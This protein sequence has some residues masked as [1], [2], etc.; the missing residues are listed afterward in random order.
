MSADIPP[1]THDPDSGDSGDLALD[2]AAKRSVGLGELVERAFLHHLSGGLEGVD[3]AR[4]QAVPQ[5][6]GSSSSDV[7]TGTSVSTSGQRRRTD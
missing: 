1:V 6:L 3:A 2:E 4:A 7:I 5:R